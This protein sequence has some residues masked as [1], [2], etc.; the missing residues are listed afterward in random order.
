MCESEKF[1]PSKPEC[2]STWLSEGHMRDGVWRLLSLK[3]TPVKPT[4]SHGHFKFVP[5]SFF[6]K[7]FFWKLNVMVLKYSE[8]QTKLKSEFSWKSF[9]EKKRVW[10]AWLTRWS[11]ATS[12]LSL[13]SPTFD[14]KFSRIIFHILSWDL[15]EVD[16]PDRRFSQR[17]PLLLPSSWTRIL[18]YKSCWVDLDSAITLLFD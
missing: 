7:R 1:W 8:V 13:T 11:E 18:S 15:S 3:L 4:D 10:P 14:T 17:K 12:L 5:Q 2:L 16:Q 9:W 6:H